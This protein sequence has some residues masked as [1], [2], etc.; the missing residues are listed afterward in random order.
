MIDD[1]EEGEEVTR[2]YTLELFLTENGMQLARG[3]SKRDTMLFALF[4][5]M[6]AYS[7]GY[8]QDVARLKKEAMKCLNDVKSKKLIDLA[9]QF[10]N[11]Y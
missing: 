8:K 10:Q 11:W 3:E 4:D 7:L 1:I 9:E 5:W 6:N 2:E